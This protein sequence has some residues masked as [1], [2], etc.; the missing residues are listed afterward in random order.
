MESADETVEG[1]VFAFSET[2]HET[3]QNKMSECTGS[4]FARNV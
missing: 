4:A 2:A 1:G 3:G